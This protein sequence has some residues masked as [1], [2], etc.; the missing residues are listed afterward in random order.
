ML[1]NFQL[2]ILIYY[3]INFKSISYFFYVLCHMHIVVSN[4]TDIFVSV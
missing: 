3:Q 4:Y 1:K 2:Y